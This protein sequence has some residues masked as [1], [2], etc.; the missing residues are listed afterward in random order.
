MENRNLYV[1]NLTIKVEYLELSVRTGNCL[2][3]EN[4]VYVGDLVQKT[5]AELL[6]VPN[7]GRKSLYEIMSELSRLGLTLGME[8][9]GWPPETIKD[10]VTVVG[11]KPI[12]PLL[13]QLRELRVP[14]EKNRRTIEKIIASLELRMQGLLP[15][16]NPLL[17]ER[18][19]I[20]K[21]LSLYRDA[22]KGISIESQFQSK[23]RS[24]RKFIELYCRWDER[25]EINVHPLMKLYYMAKDKEWRRQ[26]SAEQFLCKLFKYVPDLKKLNNHRYPRSHQIKGVRWKRGVKI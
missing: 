16:L 19:K 13:K 23:C 2:K 17:E 21:E 1:P 4:V 6:K 26:A 12:D 24:W 10:V 7:F 11:G 25:G 5:E 14:T 20:N 22:L 3:N 8:L 9:E 18:K 15:K